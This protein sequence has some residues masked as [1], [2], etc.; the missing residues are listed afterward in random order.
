MLYVGE[1]YW[2]PLF[3]IVSFEE[4]VGMFEIDCLDSYG[5]PIEHY[6]QWDVDQTMK[7][8]LNGCKEG[9]LAI[10]PEVHFANAKSKEALVVNSTVQGNDTI[11]VD[12]PDALLEEEYPLLVYVYL[13]DR[14]D[15]S[16]K[17]TIATIEIPIDKRVRP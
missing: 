12:V 17:K 15:A 7:I 6:T 5:N 11:V 8:I 4:G 10:P 14:N 1:V 3:Y 16:S 9:Y 13:S 2:P